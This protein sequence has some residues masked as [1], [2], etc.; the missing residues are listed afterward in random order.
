MLTHWNCLLV[1]LNKSHHYP[2]FA[3]TV[4]ALT[5]PFL[6]EWLDF[7]GSSSSSWNELCWN[8]TSSHEPTHDTDVNSSTLSTNRKA[9]QALPCIISEVVKSDIWTIWT[10]IF[11]WCDFDCSPKRC[12]CNM[13]FS[14]IRVIFHPSIFFWSSNSGSQGGWV[15]SQLS[16]GR[17]RATPLTDRQSVTGL[18][19]KQ[20]TH[21]IAYIHTFS[22]CKVSNE[23]NMDVFGLR[24]EARL[25]KR[26][27]TGTRRTWKHTQKEPVLSQGTH[28]SCAVRQ[29]C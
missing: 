2:C 14:D 12:R 4:N 25:P 10:L 7:Y 17:R 15:L 5:S 8:Y 19:H 9:T 28:Y 27:H 3:W 11:F 22:W 20:T 29:Q 18:T 6:S 23:S 21:F 24:K 26:T 1:Y 13:I 16:S